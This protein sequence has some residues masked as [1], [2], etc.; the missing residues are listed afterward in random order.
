VVSDSEFNLTLFAEEQ[1]W[2][3]GVDLG[4]NIKSLWTGT[5]CISGVPGRIYQKAVNNCTKEEF[6]EEIK[7]Q[8]YSCGALNELI[9][10]ANNGREL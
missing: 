1:V 4:K 5:S 2:D 7:A 10:S 8:I 6:I 9:R 3:K